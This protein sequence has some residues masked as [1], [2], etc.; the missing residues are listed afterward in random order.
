MVPPL[1]CINGSDLYAV[2]T[3]ISAGMEKIWHQ[4]KAKVVHL[5]G[6]VVPWAR[7]TPESTCR[8][9]YEIVEMI[10]THLIHDLYALKACSLTCR[11]WYTVMAPHIHHTL[12]L[13]PD[14]VNRKP[15]PLSK[16]HELGLIPLVKEIR[17]EQRGDTPWFIPQT[18][19]HHHLR[20]FYAFANVHTL[21]LQRLEIYRFIPLIERYFGHFLPTLR[22]IALFEPRCTPRQLSHFLSYFPNLDDIDIW[23][24]FPDVPDPDTKVAPLSTPKPR[25][26]L[27]LAGFF[28][29]ETWKHF[30]PLCG[31]LWFRHMD[32]CG[33]GPCV[34][35]LFGACARTLETLRFYATD[36]DTVSKWHIL[37]FSTD[38]S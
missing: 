30:I 28:L 11:S 9:P 22:S 33:S 29:A 14:I 7:A 5:F 18:F 21:R 25:G 31:G 34:P 20:H 35:I 24:V 15:K 23:R 32:L 1:G 8:V 38:S 10:A 16:L 19:S 36:H 13:G 2:L 12:T 26:Q 6:V 17:V 4:G 37:Y 27:T 3:V